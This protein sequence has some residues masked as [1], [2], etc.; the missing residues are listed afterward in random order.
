MFI[1]GSSSSP[2]KML[3]I[4]DETSILTLGWVKKNNNKKKI[5]LNI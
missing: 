1:K 5:Q 3:T 2:V 4:R